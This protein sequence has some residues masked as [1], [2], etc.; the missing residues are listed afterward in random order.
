MIAAVAQIF[1]PGRSVLV[2]SQANGTAMA[3]V[4]AATANAKTAV[5]RKIRSVRSRRI[6]SQVSALAPVARM[7]R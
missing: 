5:L 1:R 2:V 7:I 6:R 3:T 4:A